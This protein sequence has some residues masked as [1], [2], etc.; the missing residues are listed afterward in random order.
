MAKMPSGGIE[1]PLFAF[2]GLLP[3]TFFSAAV[4]KAGNS[5]VASEELITK[6]YFPRLAIPFASV[7]ACLVDFA[8]AFVLLIGMM[9]FYRVAPGWGL[10]MVPVVVVLITVAAVGIGTMLAALNVVYRDFRYL[11]PFLVQ[12][13]IFATPSI[14][15]APASQPQGWLRVLLELNPMTNLI[16]AFRAATLGGPF[17]WV[18]LLVSLVY[19]SLLCLVGCLYFRKV[20]DDFADII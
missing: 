19:V 7:G 8:F 12:L 5:V 13:G 6:V 14:Y 20:E 16:V 4:T 3:W 15:M 10:L 11:V 2:A 18:S 1:Y 17:P 9:A